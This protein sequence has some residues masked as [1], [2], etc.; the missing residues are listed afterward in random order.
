[1][2]STLDRLVA[3]GYV[4][5]IGIV[6]LVMML[7]DAQT[8][9]QKFKETF[10]N[11]IRDEIWAKEGEAGITSQDHSISGNYSYK[12][13]LPA[14]RLSN[15]RNE[16]R[17][18]GT[19]GVP[20]W[21]PHFTTWGVQVAI[22]FPKD[23]TPDDTSAEIILQYHGVQDKG[24][25]YTNPPWALRLRGK[26]L[27]VTNR[28]IEKKIA[29]NADKHEKTWTLPGEIEPG[30]WHYFVIDIHWDYRSNGDGFM[31]FYMN[32]GAPPSP[33]DILL[34]YKGPTGYNDDL[35][36]Y[37]K[38]GVYKWDWKDPSRVSISK[39]GGVTHRLLYYD[40]FEIKKN[41][42]LTG[43]ISN[44]PEANAG[45]NQTIYL[46]Q[47]SV[48]IVGSATDVDNDIDRIIWTQS[49]GPTT[50]IFKN[51]NQLK[52]E[53]S[54]LI[55]GRYVFKLKVFD[56]Q[57]NLSSDHV[58]IF[59]LK[60][61]AENPGTITADITDANC[62]AN[63]GSIQVSISGGEPPFK[64]LWS[65]GATTKNIDNLVSGEYTLTVTDNLEG[66]FSKTFNVD[67]E[68]ADLSITSEITNASC[69]Q[70]DGSIKVEAS[71]GTGPYNYEWSS[72]KA[73]TANLN[74]LAGGAYDLVVTDK[75]GCRKKFTLNVGVDPGEANHE[76]TK[77]IT[78]ASCAGDDGSIVLK[79]IGSTGPYSFSWDHGANGGKIEG[80]EPGS[81]KVTIKDKYGCY[82]QSTFTVNQD[83]GLP[84]PSIIQAGDSIFVKQQAH[85]Y[86]WYKDSVAITGGNQQ[87]LKITEA[88]TYSVQIINERNCTASSDYF[89]A[90][91]PVTMVNNS[92]K[93][94][95]TFQQV[96]FF[97]NP[98]IDQL[99]IRLLLNKPSQTE[100]TIFDL[101][102][103]IVLARNLG[104][105]NTQITEEVKVDDFTPGVYIIRTKVEDEMV[106]QRFIKQ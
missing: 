38:M 99:K 78:N 49:D 12:S 56:K 100:I 81:Y 64:Y 54:G 106:T 23:F 52:L 19:N 71:G 94:N 74:Q 29:S 53:A 9:A 44:P 31:Q 42:I 97:P 55:E 59:V 16:I 34:D 65:N 27:S 96:E 48:T 13:Y 102:G 91:D 84:K 50:A 15:P 83:P 22:Y 5:R 26:T 73:R 35:T 93:E 90:K 2:I 62:T 43:K 86:Q 51:P 76:I 32:I 61:A 89:Y 79:A 72:N 3:G 36:S 58:S 24:D 104:L 4:V 11:G 45:P 41:G 25:T 77:V 63:N 88:G 82:M 68:K 17:F 92:N 60:K 14:K 30:K 7:F 103:Q 6:V 101:N 46:P 95:Q 75:N 20:N 8:Y 87:A 21:Q 10:E 40:D 47:D 105:V 39:R 80:L 1:M 28:W 67:S 85:N 57:E 66:S 18:R 37:F 70:R 33:S 98:A 69:D